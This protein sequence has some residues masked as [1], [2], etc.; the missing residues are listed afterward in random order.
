MALHV[1]QTM[2]CDVIFLCQMRLFAVESCF[3]YH[4][5]VYF[6]FSYALFC[7][8]SFVVVPHVFFTYVLRNRIIATNLESGVTVTYTDIVILWIYVPYHVIDW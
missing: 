8:A 5:L 7:F 3:T 1:R 4:T 2:P 6:R